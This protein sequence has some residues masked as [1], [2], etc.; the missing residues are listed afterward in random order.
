M[1]EAIARAEDEANEY[2]E[3]PGDEYL[4]FAQAYHLSGSPRDGAE[5]FSLI[6]NSVLGA[7]NFFDSGDERERKVDEDP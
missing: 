7:D 4:G 1:Y 6:R 3:T 2:A 5:V